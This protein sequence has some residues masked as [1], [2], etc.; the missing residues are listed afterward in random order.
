MNVC[1]MGQHV[2]PGPIVR[3]DLLLKY[4]NVFSFF[5][6]LVLEKKGK[7]GAGGEHRSG[8]R[9]KEPNEDIY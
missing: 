8:G 5:L 1:A 9:R 2:C 4:V 6:F 3:K 7:G